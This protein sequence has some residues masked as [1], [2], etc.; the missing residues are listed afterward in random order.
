MLNEMNVE[1]MESV[2]TES[3]VIEAISEAELDG[4]SG[5]ASIDM[6]SLSSF[7]QK[8]MAFGQSTVAGPNGAGTTNLFASSE[9]ESIAG[10]FFNAQN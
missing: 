2:V 3:G 10:Q 9:I 7:M 4:V 6:G 5:G 8:D 1:A